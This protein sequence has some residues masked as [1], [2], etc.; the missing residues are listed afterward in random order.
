MTPCK[1]PKCTKPAEAG[2]QT[3]GDQVCKNR[4]SNMQRPSREDA[5]KRAEKRGVSKGIASVH[6]EVVVAGLRGA[7]VRDG[8]PGWKDD[9]PGGGV[10]MALPPG[11]RDVLKERME[12]VEMWAG[13]TQ[14]A[15][16]RLKGAA[17]EL[18]EFHANEREAVAD[19]CHLLREMMKASDGQGQVR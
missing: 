6:K 17:K 18:R 10:V 3:C 7:S 9:L 13:V 19:L 4:V 5:D 1:N 12:A 15:I 8:A 16:D 11:I 2:Q 14:G